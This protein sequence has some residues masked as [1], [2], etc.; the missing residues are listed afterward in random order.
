MIKKPTSN[1]HT[2]VP[3]S[4]VSR[5]TSSNSSWEQMQRDPKPNIRQKERKSKLDISI[6]SLPSELRKSH[7]NEVKDITKA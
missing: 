7:G 6:G 1:T 3:S 5:E 4:S 2:S